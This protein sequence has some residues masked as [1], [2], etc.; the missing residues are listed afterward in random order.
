MTDGKVRII[1][2]KDQALVLFEFLNRYSQNDQLSIE[3]Q[4]EQ[5]ILWDLT[6][7]LEKKLIEP[8]QDDYQEK[9]KQSRAIIRDK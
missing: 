2:S 5:R 1:L 9:L 4:S 3:D 6:C 7:D 8:F